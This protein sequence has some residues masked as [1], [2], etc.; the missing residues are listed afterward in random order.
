MA[1]N[2]TW[3]ERFAGVLLALFLAIPTAGFTW[4]YFNLASR[5]TEPV[6]PTMALWVVCAVLVGIGFVFPRMLVNGLGAF[7]RFLHSLLGF[8]W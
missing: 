1:S 6:I 7:W 5:S 3:S 4:L 2:I 8:R